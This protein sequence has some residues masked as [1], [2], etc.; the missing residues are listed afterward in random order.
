MG[1]FRK[2][3]I[4]DPSTWDKATDKP[5]VYDGAMLYNNERKPITELELVG[6]FKTAWAFLEKRKKQILST[7]KKASIKTILDKMVAAGQTDPNWI[8]KEQIDPVKVEEPPKLP[9]GNVYGGY[10]FSEAQMEVI[11]GFSE[12]KLVEIGE[13]MVSGRKN[14]KRSYQIEQDYFHGMGWD[15]HLFVQLDSNKGFPELEERT[16]WDYFMGYEDFE[17]E[18]EIREFFEGNEYLK[19]NPKIRDELIKLKIEYLD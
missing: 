2:F 6:F 9:A 14:H 1:L 12:D 10:S 8:D 18:T 3:K 17:T 5:I 4:L 16:M 7:K 15:A 13:I 19:K 11:S